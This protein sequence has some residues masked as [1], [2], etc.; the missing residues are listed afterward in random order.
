MQS[1]LATKLWAFESLRYRGSGWLLDRA[2]PRSPVG[3]IAVALAVPAVWFAV[4]VALS[5]DRHAVLATPDVL[6]QLW[7]FPMHVL[8]IRLVGN[9]WGR[10]LDPALAGLALD[11]GPRLRIRR[12]ALGRWASAGAIAAAVPFIA[13]DLWFGL[14]PDPTS[15]LIPF[16]DP[17]MWDMAKLGRGVHGSMMGLWIVEWLLFGYL[18]WLQAW[19]LVAW[20][21]ELRRTNFR[22]HIMTVLVGDGYR[23]AFSL[24]GNTATV[25]LVFALGNLGF[26]HYTGELIPREKVVIESAGDFMQNMSDVLSTTL[27]FVLAL[28]AIIAFVTQLR[29]AMT[30]AV[31]AE[32]A[33]AGDAALQTM[34][35]MTLEARVEAQGKLLRAVVYLREVE[36]IGGRTMI[37]IGAKALLP[38]VTTVLK[39]AKMQVKP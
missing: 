15:G 27:L 28:G 29:S 35:G 4:V 22:P 7:F 14:S 1:D 3:V 21:R 34:D 37:T 20:T 17:E 8:A 36:K 32:F 12:G 2:L 33:E 24:F 18:L 38:L 5:H 11:D 25:C 6:G 9:L 31:N 30:K 26:I 16:D 39:I 19:L 10:G 23:H 13:R